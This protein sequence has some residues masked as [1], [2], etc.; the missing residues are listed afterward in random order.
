MMMQP[1]LTGAHKHLTGTASNYTVNPTS[2]Q[3]SFLYTN[4]TV[5]NQTENQGQV[6]YVKT[7]GY[8]PGES[9]TLYGYPWDINKYDGSYIYLWIT[10][11]KRGRSLVIQAIQRKHGA[12][13]AA[14]CRTRQCGAVDELD[15]IDFYSSSRSHPDQQL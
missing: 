2:T 13:S 14:L 7:Y 9:T 10:E 3:P 5:T 6:T 12:V 15:P 1:S 11:L 4:W 8:I